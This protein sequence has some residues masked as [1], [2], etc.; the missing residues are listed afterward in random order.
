VLAEYLTGASDRSWQHAFEGGEGEDYNLHDYLKAMTAM[1]GI[2]TQIVNEDG[3]ASYDATL[4]APAH[5]F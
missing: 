3:A 4:S 2:A 1:R 5:A